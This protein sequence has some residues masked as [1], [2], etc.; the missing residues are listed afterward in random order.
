MTEKC[1]QKKKFYSHII[2]IWG[3]PSGS[4]RLRYQHEENLMHKRVLL[5]K[6]K[7]NRKI[8]MFDL[9]I[10]VDTCRWFFLDLNLKQ[11]Y[12]FDW[13]EIRSNLRIKRCSLSFTNWSFFQLGIVGAIWRIDND[14][15]LRFYESKLFIESILNAFLYRSKLKKI[16]ESKLPSRISI[17]I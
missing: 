1:R 10:F 5:N 2:D 9:I 4:G 14:S 8:H 12:S 7:R 17:G 15:F 6:L 13:E 16:D 3:W 11:F